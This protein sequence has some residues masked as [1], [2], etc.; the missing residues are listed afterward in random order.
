VSFDNVLC[1]KIDDFHV[2]VGAH[3][4]D[5]AVWDDNPEGEVVREDGGDSLVGDGR[6]EVGG[7]VAPDDKCVYTF[8]EVDA[9]VRTEPALVGVRAH[10][11]H[12][13]GHLD[14]VE[15]ES[16]ETDSAVLLVEDGDL[17]VGPNLSRSSAGGAGK[18]AGLTGS[19]SS[20]TLGPWAK[21]DMLGYKANK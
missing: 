20:A 21:K 9:C 6:R 17:L 1:A 15:V 3:Q 12:N 7:V 16:D 4:H 11:G 18:G 19:F 5:I 8:S 14:I 13:I 2:V 10:I